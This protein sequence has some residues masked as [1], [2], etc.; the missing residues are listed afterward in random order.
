MMGPPIDE[1]SCFIQ[2]SNKTVVYMGLCIMLVNHPNWTDLGESEYF[3]GLI[4]ACAKK[5]HAKNTKWAY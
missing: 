3:L 1:H 4:F 5:D 2:Y